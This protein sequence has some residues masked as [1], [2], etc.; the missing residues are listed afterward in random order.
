MGDHTSVHCWLGDELIKLADSHKYIVLPIIPPLQPH[1]SPQQM[2]TSSHHSDQSSILRCHIRR[3]LSLATLGYIVCTCIT[4]IIY[5]WFVV[6]NL[7]TF[8]SLWINDC[9][10]PSVC[11]QQIKELEGER[12]RERGRTEGKKDQLCCTATHQSLLCCS[13]CQPGGM[14]SESSLSHHLPYPLPATGHR[15]RL[16]SA[17]WSMN[18]SPSPACSEKKNTDQKWTAAVPYK[19]SFPLSYFLCTVYLVH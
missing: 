3:F 4:G 18:Y 11:T 7:I 13:P 12:E 8:T 5:I 14:G 17:Q 6:C 9:E 2:M 10:Y 19:Y 15:G 1:H 16:Q